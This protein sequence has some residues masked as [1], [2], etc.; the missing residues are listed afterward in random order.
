MDGKFAQKAP[1]SCRISVQRLKLS[2]TP[3]DQDARQ[4]I[5]ARVGN[6][7]AGRSLRK[8]EMQIRYTLTLKE[9][10]R[11]QFLLFRHIGRIF[12]L[13]FFLLG[14]VYALG[15]VLPTALNLYD[16]YVLHFPVS[17]RLLWSTLSMVG[18]LLVE[19]PLLFALFTPLGWLTY[20]Q[21]E[22]EID[23]EGVRYRQ[24]RFNMRVPWQSL[25]QIEEDGRDIY[26]GSK[27]LSFG[28][29]V[30]VMLPKRAFSSAQE[31][32][33]FFDQAVA[34][35]EQAVG[36]RPPQA[37]SAWPPEPTKREDRQ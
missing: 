20:R 15:L 29:M 26:I 3:G 12:P 22:L 25:A 27:L 14:I 24:R 33:A 9:Y 34:Y 36:G 18:I 37:E 8:T 32:Q 5:D 1:I 6:E 31:A 11:Y 17:D 21:P 35:R 16:R 23:T 28:R 30:F 19:A 2:D 7:S 4:V 10:Y 13:L